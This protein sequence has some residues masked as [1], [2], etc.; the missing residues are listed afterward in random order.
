MTRDKIAFLKIAAVFRI[1]TFL[2][3]TFSNLTKTGDAG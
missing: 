1:K 2:K 3:M